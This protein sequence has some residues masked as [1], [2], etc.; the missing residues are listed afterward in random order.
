MGEKVRF[1]RVLINLI[2]SAEASFNF[3]KARKN[4]IKWFDNI[5]KKYIHI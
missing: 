3:T 2:N 5:F 4:I 1:A